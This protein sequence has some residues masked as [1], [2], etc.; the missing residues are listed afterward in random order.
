MRNRTVGL[1]VIGIALLI[2]LI[3]FWFNRALT[4]II[5]SSCSH[6]SSCPMW[7]TLNFQ[8]NVGLA[9]MGLIIAAGLYLVFFAKDDKPPSVIVKT[10]KQ[11]AAQAAARKPSRENYAAVMRELDE[12][13][14]SV[15]G[16]VIDGGGA[17]VQ[18]ELVE[19]T[20]LGKVKVTRVLDA[21]E[22]KGLIERRRRGMTN[23][24]VLKTQ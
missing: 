19:K 6:G 20:G 9:V 5:N 21:L 12:E 7:G 10:I 22:V 24:V 1:L 18:S 8:T 15:L 14:R 16:L 3:V 13:Q 17:A 11:P 23:V 2:G 4:D